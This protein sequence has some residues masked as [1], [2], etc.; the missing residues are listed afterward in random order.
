M[1][2]LKYPKIKNK[3]NAKLFPLKGGDSLVLKLQKQPKLL[4][5]AVWVVREM[6]NLVCDVCSGTL[7]MS[8]GGQK[9]VCSGCGIEYSV[10]R[11][12]EKV[13]ERKGNGGTTHG[14]ESVRPTPETMEELQLL[15][16][17][18]LKICDWE[19]AGHVYEKIL[20]K[21]P[22]D[23]EAFDIINKLK[24]WKHMVVE[25]GVL[26]KYSGTA[27]EVVLPDAV[28]SIGGRVFSGGRGV[29]TVV[30]TPNVESIE[31]EAFYQSRRLKSVV[32]LDGVKIIGKGAFFEC[33]ALENCELGDNVEYIDDE[34]FRGCSS[35]KTIKLPSNLKQL[36]RAAFKNCIN[37]TEIT[38][39]EK[40]TCISSSLFEQCRNLAVV[41]LP[42]G[43]K[44]IET[45][46]FY[47]C[48]ALQ[49][50][51]L[52][53]EIE[54]LCSACFKETGLASIE[55]PQKITELP[56]Q[57]FDRCGNLTSVKIPDNIERI[58]DKA[59]YCCV[60]LVSLSLNVKVEVG[61]QVFFNCRKLMYV[62]PPEDVGSDS[63]SVALVDL[64]K[65]V[66]GVCTV[67]PEELFLAFKNTPYY[68][69]EILRRRSNK[70]CDRCAGKLSFFGKCKV[71][72]FKL[73]K[74]NK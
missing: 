18:Y 4:S 54:E 41:N 26:K 21:S 35:L 11:L 61:R 36:E 59:F 68:N 44:K 60:G 72:G 27:T 66:P 56:S 40:I 17:K 42:E 70:L 25:K 37:L 74:E 62:N 33:D 58:G 57:C 10:E 53:S 12:R 50:I 7:V 5:G 52:P 49:E 71:C 43:I 28:V 47:G 2:S 19:N 64:T 73:K 31:K 46:A 63:K 14:I 24:V 23:E 32:G 69:S 1:I 65:P 39:P 16:K 38:I 45:N 48:S 9:A 20:D 15:G 8:S 55:I 13:G 30:F 67:L 29:E 3:R 6:A 51:K 22:T 34:A